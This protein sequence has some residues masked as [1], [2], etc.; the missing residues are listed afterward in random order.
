MVWELLGRRGE[1]EG[2]TGLLEGRREE[3]GRSAGEN[4]FLC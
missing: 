3:N 2:Q 4:G 1:G